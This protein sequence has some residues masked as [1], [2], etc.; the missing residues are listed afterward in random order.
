MTSSRA[1]ETPLQIVYQD[2]QLLVLDKPSGLLAVPGRGPDL[3]D[4]LSA[5]AQAQFPTA[6]VVHRLDRDTSGLLVMALDA[7]TQRALNRQFAAQQVSKRYVAVV[8]GSPPTD[9][10]IIDLPMR[11][12]FDNPPRH[13]IDLEQGRAARTEW[14]AIER[15]ADRARLEVSPKT[16]RS[17]Q[18]RLHLRTIGH[19]ILGDNLYAPPHALAMSDRLLLHAE[20]LCLTHPA[21]GQEITWR[22][23]CPF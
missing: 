3:Q 20:E 17:H 12:D 21:S 14:R 23:L 15:Q 6:L 22:S 10:G 1:R 13:M 11:K 16:G 18:I 5:R 4:C 19:P 8:F 9:A 2:E 7:A